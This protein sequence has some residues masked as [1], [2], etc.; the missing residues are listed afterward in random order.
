MGWGEG[1]LWGD[2]IPT[3]GSVVIAEDENERLVSG[4]A[5]HWGG[6][7]PLPCFSP[8]IWECGHHQHQDQHQERQLLGSNSQWLIEA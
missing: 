8:P 4:P 3:A 1:E 7:L 2:S 5:E 6:V